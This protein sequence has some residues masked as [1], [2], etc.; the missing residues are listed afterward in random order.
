MNIPIPLSMKKLALA[1][2]ACCSLSATAGVVNVGSHGSYTDEFPGTDA[3]GRNAYPSGEPRL[4]GNALN[5][6]VPTNDWW[7]NQLYVNHASNLFN[8]PLGMRTTDN[9]LVIVKTV[10]YQGAPADTPIEV[11]VDG[12]STATTTVS[13]YTDWTVTFRWENEAGYM[14]ATTGVGMPM[15]YFTKSSANNVKINI[16][17]GQ[18]TIN[19]ETVL[20]TGSYNGMNYAIYAPEGSQWT[21]NG[22][23]VESSLNGKDYWSVVMLPAG[24]AASIAADWRKYAFVFPGDTQT[25]WTYDE[26][27]GVVT[28]DYIV[29]PDVKEGDS[30]TML[31]GL[32][33]HQWAHL[34][35]DAPQ[36]TNYSYE[37]VRGEL[38]MMPANKFSTSLTFHGILPTLPAVS[39]DNEAFSQDELDSLINA[40]VADH[41]FQDWTDSYNDGQLLNR[42]VQTARIAKLYGNEEQFQTAFDIIKAKIEDWLSYEAGEIA[43]LFYYH[44][45][46][47]SLLGYPAGH[48]QDS[49]INDHHF[50]WGYIIHAAAFVEQY[51]PGWVD[52]YGDMISLLIRDAAST[53]RN[54]TMFPY[55][56]SFSPYAGHCWANG[57]AAM[58]IGNDQESTSESMQFNSALIHW[59]ELTGNK[60]IRDLGIYMYVT[61]QTA[62]EEYWFDAHDRN[63]P[64]NYGYFIAS[65]VFTNGYDAQTFWGA[66]LDGAYGIQLYPIHSGSFYLLNDGDFA[67]RFWKTIEKDTEILNT[68]SA[69]T[70]VNL[71][72]DTMWQFLAMMDAPRA[73]EM[74]KQGGNR[75][76]K[77][78]ISQALTYHWIQSLNEI[79]VF[80]STMTADHPL[81]MAFTKDGIIT[82]VAQNYSSEEITV[83]FSDGFSMK[84]APKTLAK[85]SAVSPSPVVI[86]TSPENNSEIKLGEPVEIAADAYVNVDGIEIEKVE[87]LAN[88]ELI[89]TTATAP[90]QATWTPT[91]AGTYIITAKAYS[92][93]N[94]TSTSSAVTIYVYSGDTPGG[95]GGSDDSGST[96][97]SSVGECAYS[98]NEVSDG[99]ELTLGYDIS[100]KTVD[101]N[102]VVTSTLLDAKEGLAVAYIHDTTNGFQETQME[103]VSDATFT[104]TVRGYN[105]GDVVKLAVKF[106][107]AGGLS[108]TAFFEYEVGS[109]CENSGVMN[110]FTSSQDVVVFP[111]PASATITL[112]HGAPEAAHTTIVSDAGVVMYDGLLQSDQTIDVSAWRTGFYIVRVQSG[113]NI[114]TIPLIKE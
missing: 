14:D 37:T 44:K 86:I 68:P 95:S 63:L 102:V 31:M 66:G 6:P 114:A 98:S 106:A 47:T 22:N 19:G 104:G 65:R 99:Q 97:G 103:K 9:G 93:E 40:V 53:D 90:Y 4:S 60:A 33:P 48:G 26:A 59:G 32:L 12:V 85:E 61:E 27:T 58:G 113:S 100:F 79:G 75:T 8:Y 45:D 18:V 73:L 76:L 74:Y 108:R 107:F 92:T 51:E 111:N 11:T 1:M 96:G 41:G 67:E 70:S 13:D 81:A 82:Y 50:H 52:K 20:V 10:I 2:I 3:A 94:R 43:F 24:D 39:A 88:G 42:L 29:T 21:K 56:R 30:G 83:T 28:T 17:Q 5:K 55:L 23:S 72:H 35:A 112:R 36:F 7:S 49:L 84:V 57:M 71:W 87:F 34:T 80:E 25:K 101:G 62:I 16:N 46:W 109:S 38:K 91:A 54:D 89:A 64:D 78:G 15:V 69:A 110:V 77:F 105:I